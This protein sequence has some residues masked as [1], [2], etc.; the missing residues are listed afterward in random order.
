[1]CSDFLKRGPC[2]LALQS[3]FYQ[4]DFQK[5]LLFEAEW[6]KQW[7]KYSS[8][9]HSQIDSLMSPLLFHCTVLLHVGS[10]GLVLQM[11]LQKDNW[12]FC[13]IQH[14]WLIIQPGR[15]KRCVNDTVMCKAK[16]CNKNAV[17]HKHRTFNQESGVFYFVSYVGDVCDVF[18]V[19]ILN[20]TM[21]FFP[22]PN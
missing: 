8:G 12:N 6:K 1:M 16:A 18:Y 14:R 17:L 7:Q 21:S 15:T 11:L 2:S 22:K 5:V 4:L 9:N 3:D 10:L 19:L 13:R 20:P